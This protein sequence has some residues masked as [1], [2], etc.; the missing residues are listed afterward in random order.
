MIL[1]VEEICLNHLVKF[2]DRIDF[3]GERTEPEQYLPT[4]LSAL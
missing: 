4:Q 3:F 1:R 2:Q